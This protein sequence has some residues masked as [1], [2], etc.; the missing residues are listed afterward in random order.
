MKK[1]REDAKGEDIACVGGWGFG[2]EVRA[3]T[4]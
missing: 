1:G 2:N 4:R 3:G